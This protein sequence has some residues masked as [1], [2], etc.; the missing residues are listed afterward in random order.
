MSSFEISIIII[1]LC[2][3][4]FTKGATGM[5]LPLICVP[6]ITPILGLAHAICLLLVSVM[7]SNIWQIWSLRS[8]RKDEKLKFL[9][10]LTITGCFGIVLGTWMLGNLPERALTFGLG[11]LLLGY[12][13]LKVTNPSFIVSAKIGNR[14]STLI[15][16]SSGV[17]QG[18]TGVSAPIGVTFI[19]AM[20]LNRDLMVFSISVMFMAF[21]L[22]QVPAM[23][24]GGTLKLEWLA[25]GALALIPLF[26]FMPIGRAF[27]KK[28]S[29]KAFDRMIL[30]FLVGMGFKLIIGF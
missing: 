7:V 23:Y 10:P 6:I 30:A 27:S 16:L 1:A 9:A 5:G 21:S 12:F 14:L 18:A 2:L 11:V 22:V 8:V 26:V 19:H 17:L 20:K 28:L 3:G 13:I 4:G 24:F 25:Q 15:G 29:Q